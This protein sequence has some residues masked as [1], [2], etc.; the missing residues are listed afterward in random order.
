VRVLEKAGMNNTI[1]LAHNMGVKSDLEAVPSMALGTADISVMEMVTAY[2]TF[3]T[4]GKTVKPFY[5]TSITAHDG[6]ILEKFRHEKP[7]QVMSEE[8]AQ[9]MLHMLRRAVNEGTSA[10]LRSQFGLTNDIAGKTG[11]TQSNTD[12]WFIGITPKLVVGAWVGGDDPSIRFRTTALGQGART[13]LP[14]VGEFFRLTRKDK[15]LD[16]VNLAR[17]AVLPEDLERKIDCDFYKEDRNL[18]RKLS[19][20]KEKKKNFGEEKEGLLKRMFKKKKN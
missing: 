3:A 4:K 17:F 1:Q 8:T 10:S 12:G 5:L 11:T 2:S 9:L 6:T 7:K 20:R 18:F 15:T 14:L 19:G 16:S 13:A